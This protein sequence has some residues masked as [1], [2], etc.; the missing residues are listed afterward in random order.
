MRSRRCSRERMHHSLVKTSARGRVRCPLVRTVYV[1]ARARTASH[2][3]TLRPR[4]PF[5]LLLR[6]TRLPRRALSA[7]ITSTE[8]DKPQRRRFPPESTSVPFEL[9]CHVTSV[10]KRVIERFRQHLNELHTGYIEGHSSDKV[11]LGWRGI[12]GNFRTIIDIGDCSFPLKFVV[13]TLLQF[14][15]RDIWQI[16]V[17]VGIEKRKG[18]TTLSVGSDDFRS[19]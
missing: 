12:R 10:Y 13:C 17:T 6:A 8:P 14:L 3:C 19:K 1:H 2:T 11:R 9:K 18:R 4:R 7:P 5:F 15:R 16:I